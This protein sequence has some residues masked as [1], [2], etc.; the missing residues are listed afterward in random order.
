MIKTPDSYWLEL[1]CKSMVRFAHSLYFAK[2]PLKKEERKW[3]VVE[4][5]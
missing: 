1:N 5:P 2:E 4:E 3:N